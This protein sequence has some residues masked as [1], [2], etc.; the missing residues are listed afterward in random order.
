LRDAVALAGAGWQAAAEALIGDPLADGDA[1]VA[2]DDP[3]A[4][5]GAV[6]HTLRQGIETVR[7]LLRKR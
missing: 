2:W 5:V 6:A 4:A 1:V 3:Q 7:D